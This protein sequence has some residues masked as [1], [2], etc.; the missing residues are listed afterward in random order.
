M[1][2][3]PSSCTHHLSPVLPSQPLSS[4]SC[5]FKDPTPLSPPRH[6]AGEPAYMC[7]PH[8]VATST[9]CFRYQLRKQGEWRTMRCHFSWSLHL[10]CS[11][12]FVS[13]W[14]FFFLPP[15]HPSTSGSRP[16]FQLK[17]S[18]SSNAPK[19]S[20]SFFF[21]FYLFLPSLDFTVEQWWRGTRNCDDHPL[22]SLIVWL[23]LS[24]VTGFDQDWLS[25]MNPLH[26]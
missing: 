14:C 24:E 25:K 8:G 23:S 3:Y 2:D 18:S 5:L 13:N 1:F 15:S 9:H 19:V 7:R 11:T 4:T 6:C 16:N 21:I 26:P 20:F 22:S 12:L 10:F 17:C